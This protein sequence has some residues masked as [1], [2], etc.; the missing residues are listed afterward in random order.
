MLRLIISVWS[1]VARVMVLTLGGTL[2]GLAAQARTAG[3]G[4]SVRPNIVLIMAD[5]MGYECVSSNGGSTYRTPRIDALAR[6]GIRFLNG[7]SQPICTP[8]RVQIM[9]GFYNNRNYI[10]FGF[11]D[12]EAPTF[13][14]ILK[15]AGYRTCIAGKWQLR[16]GLEGPGKFGFDEYCLWL[17]TRQPPRY[18]NPGFEING[19]QVAYPGK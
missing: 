2:V 18:V 10:R 17:L 11:L 14:H 16:G 7:H 12:P 15:A 6:S 3:A 9:T 13:G 1:F 5:D 4:A 8:S 19:K